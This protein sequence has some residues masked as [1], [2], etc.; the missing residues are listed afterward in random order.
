MF[1]V[2]LYC[3]HAV[4]SYDGSCRW[5]ALANGL[6]HSC[7]YTYFA[8][9]VS[10]IKVFI[11]DFNGFGHVL[12]FVLFSVSENPS[13]KMGSNESDNAPDCTNGFGSHNQCYIIAA[14]L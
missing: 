1:L 7:M 12:Q 10:G 3:F 8:F 14:N 6:V 4:A 9:K 2:C 5:F 13:T 11:N